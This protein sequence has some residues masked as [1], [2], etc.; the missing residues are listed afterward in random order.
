MWYIFY[1]YPFAALLVGVLTRD[2]VAFYRNKIK[3]L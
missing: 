3:E 1:V 2:L